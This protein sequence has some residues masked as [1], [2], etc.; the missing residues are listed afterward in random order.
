MLRVDEPSKG[1]YI[2][3]G[4]RSDVKSKD[5][6]LCVSYPTRVARTSHK[7]SIWRGSRVG[8]ASKWWFRM[9]TGGED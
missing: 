1:C 6:A 7:A 5:G 9:A 8:K 2:S 4:S 3:M